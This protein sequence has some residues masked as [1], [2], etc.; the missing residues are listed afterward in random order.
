M[1]LSIPVNPE[2]PPV[3]ARTFIDMAIARL[4]VMGQLLRCWRPADAGRTTET[5]LNDQAVE[6]GDYKDIET[7]QKVVATDHR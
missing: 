7:A 1:A 3:R 6:R 2:R 5:G 4:A